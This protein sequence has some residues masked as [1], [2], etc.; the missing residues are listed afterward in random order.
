MLTEGDSGI[1][2]HTPGKS[3]FYYE[4]FILDTLNDF[5]SGKKAKAPKRPCLFILID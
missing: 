2:L 3:G 5:N 4:V 1:Y